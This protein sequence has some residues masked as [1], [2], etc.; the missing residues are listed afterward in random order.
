MTDEPESKPKALKGFAAMKAKDPERMREI[1]RS[2]GAA[3]PPEKRSFS[4]DPALASESGRK[5]GTAKGKNA[6]T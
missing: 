2:G 4:R 1:A 5:G 3:T 6:K